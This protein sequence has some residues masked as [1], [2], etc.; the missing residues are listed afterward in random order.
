MS[1]DF[2]P[3]IFESFN[4][5][6]QPAKRVADTFV[7]SVHY[8]QV[9]GSHHNLLIGPRGSGKTTLLKMLQPSGL[10][11]LKGPDAVTYRQR[12]NFTG[13]F[14]ATD[15]SWYPTLTINHADPETAE[16]DRQ[17]LGRAAVTTHVLR[18][19]VRAI[20]ER[21]ETV[22][23]FRSV[24]V[25]AEQSAEF[26]AELREPWHIEP[27]LNSLIALERA[28]N[29]RL[30]FIGEL[31]LSGHDR[32]VAEL[33]HQFLSL[34]FLTAASVAFRLFDE[35]TGDPD[36]RWALCFDELE[37][38]PPW[39][40]QELM[41][42]FRSIDE[43]VLL[44]IALAPYTPE[45]L[46]KPSNAPA[47]PD[48]DYRE[49]RLWYPH[50]QDG[51]RFCK[52]LLDGLL[53]DTDRDPVTSAEQLFGT[54]IFDTDPTEWATDGTAYRTGTKIHNHFVSLSR[55]DQSFRAYLKA[56]KIDLGTL[57][58]V[59]PTDRAAALRK[60]ASLV[61]VRDVFMRS[62]DGSS[63]QGRSRKNPDPYTGAS[64]IFAMSEGNPRW[65]IG[66]VNEMLSA[67]KGTSRIP[68]SVQASAISKASHVFRMKLRL[69]PT[70]Q[71]ADRAESPLAIVDTV[72]SAISHRAL[73]ADFEPEYFG[74]FI[75]DSHASEQVQKLI[76][77]ALNAGA[78]V[79]VPDS[80]SDGVLTSVRGKRFRIAYLLAPHYKLPL[81]IG[82]SKSY[83]FFT[84]KPVG[85]EQLGM[86]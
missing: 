77:V 27:K 49:I 47:T 43:K 57:D 55:K 15:R 48:D 84:S 69:V 12:V 13:V 80:D 8:D 81:L 31:V 7:P 2:A 82:K 83:S 70:G 42:S 74:S 78:L 56:N 16:R 61:I 41:A 14:V 37:L 39:I 18:A 64:A 22:N 51:Y 26:V 58:A 38:A 67:Y 36:A 23:G 73:R 3:G 4:A 72:G 9:C 53:R 86:E 11:A 21:T 35:I 76:G 60:V 34:H 29:N 28:L 50:K 71:F 30:S 32:P 10:G 52:A 66:L 63:M 40:T 5:R 62:D 33:D 24:S 6:N 19:I 85:Q 46:Q 75:V 44:K 59:G 79:Y 17:I 54:S 25:T 20:R 65:F 1:Q 68:R 45:G